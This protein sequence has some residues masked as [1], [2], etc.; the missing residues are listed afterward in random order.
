MHVLKKDTLRT[1]VPAARGAV[2]NAAVRSLLTGPEGFASTS[3]YLLA[4]LMLPHGCHKKALL[5]L[6]M[7]GR[8][9]HSKQKRRG[10]IR[11]SAKQHQ[12]QSA[13]GQL[14]YD[15]RRKQ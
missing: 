13:R 10:S 14:V 7:A 4:V 12:P 11:Y 3:R 1:R 2:K 15:C 5:A 9:S 6:V 8:S